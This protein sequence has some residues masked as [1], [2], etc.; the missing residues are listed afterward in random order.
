M[1][2][3]LLGDRITVSSWDNVT[4]ALRE[5]GNSAAKPLAPYA[6]AAHRTQLQQKT[7][8]KPTEA[9]RTS[10]NVNES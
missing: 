10:P 6:N 8:A 7:S 5:F 9:G 4:K 2:S 1:R 3:L